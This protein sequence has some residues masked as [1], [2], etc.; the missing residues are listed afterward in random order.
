MLEK[1]DIPV[2]PEG[3]P[4]VVSMTTLFDTIKSISLVVNDQSSPLPIRPETQPRSHTDVSETMLSSCW[5][6]VLSA[7]A[8]LLDLV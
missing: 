2:I 8:L 6:A 5:S 3:Y 1:Q 7:L 4:L